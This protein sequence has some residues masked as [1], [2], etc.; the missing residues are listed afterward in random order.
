MALT[1][2]TG[3]GTVR[4]LMCASNVAWDPAQ[5]TSAHGI[6]TCVPVRALP[7][8]FPAAFYVLASLSDLTEGEHVFGLQADPATASFRSEE[9]SIT[10]ETSLAL[11]VLPVIDCRILR[12]GVTNFIVTVDGHDLK[13]AWGFWVQLQGQDDGEDE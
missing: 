10:V 7:F 1:V 4:G 9:Q 13:P 11:I 2:P 8:R 6:F 12:E 5:R 3:L